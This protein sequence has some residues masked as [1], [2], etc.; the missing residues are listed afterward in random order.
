MGVSKGEFGFN[1]VNKLFGSAKNPKTAEIIMNAMNDLTKHRDKAK[2]VPSKIL[3]RR[4][5]RMMTNRVPWPEYTTLTS[6]KSNK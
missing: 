3:I 4:T 5:N 2:V 1:S 6:I